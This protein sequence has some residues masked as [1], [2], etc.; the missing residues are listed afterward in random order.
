[1][2]IKEY[3][4]GCK[5][6]VATEQHAKE[7]APLLRHEDSLEVGAYG[8]QSNEASLLNAL[9]KD[10]ITITALDAEGAPF[11][12]LGV[13]QTKDMPYIWLLGS[14]G[15][16]DNWYVF[17]K[18]SKE[19]LP[20]L[21]K[22]YPVVTNLVLKDYTASVRW[23][24]WLGAQFIREVELEGQMF[25]EFILKREEPTTLS[26]PLQEFRAKTAVLNNQ[27]REM[28]GALTTREEIDA[29]NPLE[30]FF[31]EGLY[32]R[33]IVTP[34]GQLLVSMIHKQ[35]HPYFLMSGDISILTEDGVKRYKAPC[36]GMTPGNTQRI[37]Y[38]HEETTWITVQHTHETDLTK[39]EKDVM[40]DAPVLE[41][42]DIDFN[43]LTKG[44][45]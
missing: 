37:I 21:I 31:G 27:I 7:L 41:L 35:T 9:N 40:L 34:A 19:L 17:A 43:L 13:G 39:I 15:V 4:N 11:A 5:A 23:L 28:P 29:V 33:K 3:S 26:M 22:D 20:Y 44:T 32:V 45:K 30:H 10:D 16:K 24:K 1:M 38:T 36:F 25:Y 12:M 18:A 42:S 8:F 14:A 6:V 2:L